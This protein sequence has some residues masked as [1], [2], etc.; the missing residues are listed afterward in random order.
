LQRA[1][2]LSAQASE[3]VSKVE[4]PES[5]VL[6]RLNQAWRD[7]EFGNSRLARSGAVSALRE[8][9][10]PAVRTVTALVLARSGDSAHA[11]A[12]LADLER[13][14]ASS[15]LL[16]AYWLPAIRATLDINHKDFAKAVADLQVASPYELGIPEPT[17]EEAA[18]FLPIYVRGQAYILQHR[19]R[20]AAA[21]FQKFIDYRGVTMNSPLAA[22]ANLQL[23]RAYVEQ[24]DS[25][26]ARA[27]YKDF[28]TLWKDADLDIPILKRA[29]AEY[30]K[31]Q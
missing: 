8:M 5:A 12:I 1:R 30:A 13:H 25:A 22:L 26:K 15:V 11:Q 23:A 3:S 9:S 27:A 29:K 4:Q 31:L 7:A 16:T 24:G 2:E 18:P 19:G 28:L 14:A 10:S 21:E 20:E 6:M 17:V